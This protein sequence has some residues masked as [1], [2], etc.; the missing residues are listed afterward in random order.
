MHDLPLEIVVWMHGGFC[1]LALGS[2]L[3]RLRLERKTKNV[4]ECKA[5]PQNEE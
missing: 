5:H 3:E 1:G 4:R 2:H